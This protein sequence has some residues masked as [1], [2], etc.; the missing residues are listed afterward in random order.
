MRLRKTFDGLR[1]S[2]MPDSVTTASGPQ[3]FTGWG[4]FPA[5]TLEEEII[6]F[7]VT[8]ATD[9]SAI[10]QVECRPGG[11]AAVLRYGSHERRLSGAEFNTTSQRMELRAALE[12]LKALKAP[13]SVTLETDS[14][15]LCE[16]GKGNFKIKANAEIWGELL[17]LIEKGD[18]KV[19]FV[20]VKGHSGHPVNELCDQ[21]A[22]QA[23][24]DLLNEY[25]THLL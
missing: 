22:K 7:E 16:C 20:K 19:T 11:W 12:G 14:Q 25:T 15:Y 18:H 3:Y 23:I 6:M 8:I 9:G 1:L 10:P 4:F 13:C 24:K 5:T 17:D 2:L 21:L